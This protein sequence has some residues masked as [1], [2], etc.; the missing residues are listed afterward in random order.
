MEVDPPW[1]HSPRAEGPGQVKVGGRARSPMEAGGRLGWPRTQSGVWSTSSVVLERRCSRGGDFDGAL[2]VPSGSRGG[3]LRRRGSG[4][5]SAGPG[6]A[7]PCAARAVRLLPVARALR[8]LFSSCG[9]VR[10]ALAWAEGSGCRSR[11][12]SSFRRS[13]VVLGSRMSTWIL[14]KWKYCDASWANEIR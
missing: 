4:S 9:S 5:C 10:R 2:G 3:G 1:V 11:L 6:R 8:S 14:N 13:L 7:S 12:K